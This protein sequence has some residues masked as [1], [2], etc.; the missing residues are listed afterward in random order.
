[1]FIIGSVFKVIMEGIEIDTFI[2]SLKHEY[3]NLKTVMERNRSW[4]GHF[5]C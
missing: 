1:M 3:E 2:Q 4:R 5:F